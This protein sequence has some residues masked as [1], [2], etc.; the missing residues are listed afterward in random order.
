MWYSSNIWQ[1]RQQINLIQVEIK[2]RLNSGN[3]CSN[4]EH[5]SSRLLS[6]NVK[7]IVYITVSLAVILVDCEADIKGG[8]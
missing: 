3:A 6:K 7:I 2:K 8:A 1:R 5:F 4:P